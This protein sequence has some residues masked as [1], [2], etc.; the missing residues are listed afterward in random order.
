MTQFLFLILKNLKR[1]RRWLLKMNIIKIG[2]QGRV[3]IPKN[4]RKNISAGE[5]MVFFEV[6]DKIVM[7]KASEVYKKLKEDFNQ[8]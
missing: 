7:E 5:G 4:L 8:L 1:N 3:V 2:S 6:D